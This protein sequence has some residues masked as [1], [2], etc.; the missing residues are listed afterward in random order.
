MDPLLSPLCGG[1][2]TLS[3]RKPV[4]GESSKKDPTHGEKGVKLDNS[5]SFV[6]HVNMVTEKVEKRNRV[7]AS[8]TSKTWGFQKQH[9]RTC[10]WPSKLAY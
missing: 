7:L 2:D 4:F 1:P 5:L 10:T 8:L 6:P 9:L 3:T